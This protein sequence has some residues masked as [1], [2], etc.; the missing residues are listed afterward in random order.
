MESLHTMLV[1]LVM[2]KNPATKAPAMATVVLVMEHKAPGLTHVMVMPVRMD[3]VMP[4]KVP[5]M[6]LE[7]ASLVVTASMVRSTHP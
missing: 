1:V 7:T 3:L 6:A 2:E 4:I 5:N